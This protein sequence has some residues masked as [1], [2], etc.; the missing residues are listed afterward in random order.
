MIIT[1]AVMTG[2][3]SF[4][5][6]ADIRWLVQ[7][8]AFERIIFFAL[9]SVTVVITGPAE[10]AASMHLADRRHLARFKIPALFAT[11]R[12]E[13]GCFRHCGMQTNFFRYSRRILV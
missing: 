10:L 1:F 8:R 2:L 3:T 4:T 12:F 11:G 13:G 5:V 6:I 9:C 7:F